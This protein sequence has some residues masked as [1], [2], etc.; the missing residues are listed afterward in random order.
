MVFRA[1]VRDNA[2]FYDPLAL[3]SEGTKVDFQLQINS[4]LYGTRFLTWLARAYS[5]EQVCRLDGAGRGSH[6]YYA[7]QF[8][9]VFGRS[10]ESAWADWIVDE[11]ASRRRISRPSASTRS[12]RIRD[13]T[14][15]AL[16]SVSRAYLRP[17]RDRSTRPSTTP[18][19]SRTS[20]PST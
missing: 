10:L 11:K 13:L 12:R 7:A 1:M 20:A 15:R 16:G 4:Y 18:A 8:R 6:G 5:P 9:H 19:W 17:A 3:V 14:A 2:P